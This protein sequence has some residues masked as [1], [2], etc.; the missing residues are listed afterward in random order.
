MNWYA[1]MTRSYFAR[2]LR[3]WYEQVGD[4]GRFFA[5]CWPHSLGRA[6]DTWNRRRGCSALA[7]R[8]QRSSCGNGCCSRLGPQTATT[9]TR[10]RR[11]TRRPGAGSGR[12]SS[13][14]TI[15]NEQR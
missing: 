7:S 12:W 2:W 3:Q 1:E 8:Q 11:T 14:A 15:H 4:P 6:R 10:M 5:T 13:T 9:P